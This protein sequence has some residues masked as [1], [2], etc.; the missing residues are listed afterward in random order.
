MEEMTNDY[1]E[2]YEEYLEE[3]F[4]KVPI[5]WD[6]FDKKEDFIKCIKF[7]YQNPGATIYYNLE[8]YSFEYDNTNWKDLFSRYGSNDWITDEKE[9][10]IYNE[11]PEVLTVYRGST[12]DKGISWTLDKRVAEWFAFESDQY[13]GKDTKVFEKTIRKS[14]IR[15]I[16][17]DMGEKEIILV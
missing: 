2:N 10:E 7:A 4:E 9:L 8:E 14:D 12:N 5:D 6:M 11:L 17:L 16:I 15:A 1:F 13:N 3:E